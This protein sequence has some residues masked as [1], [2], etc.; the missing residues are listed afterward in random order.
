MRYKIFNLDQE[1]LVT[2]GLNVEESLLLDWILNFKDGNGM[3]RRFFEDKQDMGYWIDYGTVVKELPILFK[4]PTKDM[5]EKQ[6][7]KLERNNKDKVGRMLKGNLSKVLTPKKQIIQGEKGV[8][9]SNIYVVVNRN[10][11]DL[12]KGK[13]DS[14][15]DEFIEDDEV[16]V[17]NDEK[18]EK[19]QFDF[20]LD[21]M[22]DRPLVIQ[23]EKT[24]EKVIPQYNLLSQKQKDELLIEK[25]HNLGWSVGL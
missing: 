25:L 11:I 6:L 12:L 8:K 18:V 1:I 17:K 20:T 14:N 19:E 16:I 24:L 5:D 21:E 10:I 3:K 4:Q 13:V 2:L 7:K 22:K 23:L 15:F 9:G